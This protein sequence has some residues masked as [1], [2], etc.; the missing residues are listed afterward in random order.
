MYQEERLLKILEQLNEQQSMS[1]SEICNRFQVSRDTARRDIVK[2]VEQ[3]AVIRTHGGVSLPKLK[4]TLLAYRERVN[5]YSEEKMRIGAKAQTLIKENEKY[6]FDVSTTVSY[7]AEQLKKNV[8]VFTHSLDIAGILSNQADISL[9]L[10]G[11][12]LNV[13]NRFFFDMESIHQV[14]NMHFDCAFLG[15]AAIMGD[16]IYFEDKDD[17]Y[18][19]NT[20]VKRTSRNIVLADSKKF[21][22]SSY[23]KGIDWQDIDVIIT[24]KLPPQSFVKIFQDYRIE[25]LLTD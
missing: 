12:Q 9:F 4:E 19:K 23:Y 5:A 10:F 24:D 16:G 20:V 3:G 7:L 15:A 14:L 17:A 8:D 13:N 22:L 21:S 6:Y 2:L 11:G 1:V 18:I 25:L